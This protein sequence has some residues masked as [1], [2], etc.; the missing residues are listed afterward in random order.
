MLDQATVNLPDG[1]LCQSF[2]SFLLV[3][4]LVSPSSTR[5][6]S[7]NEIIKTLLLLAI[8]SPSLVYYSS[9]PTRLVWVSYLR[10]SH[11][12]PT[13][14]EWKHQVEFRFYFRRFII[15]GTRFGKWLTLYG[16]QRVFRNNP[17]L[18]KYTWDIW[19]EL[20]LRKKASELARAVRNESRLKRWMKSDEE[21][22]RKRCVKSKKKPLRVWVHRNAWDSPLME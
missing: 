19:M 1:E 13:P 6:V 5:F 14:V 10:G 22:L 7:L 15:N 3:F 18:I 9:A 21:E 8:R 16:K 2:I 17:K 12:Q 20:C 11:R 4:R